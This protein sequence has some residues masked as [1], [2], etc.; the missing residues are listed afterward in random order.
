M[1]YSY[2]TS[3]GPRPHCPG[4]IWKRRFH[5]EKRI[6]CF[7]STLRRRNLK[8]EVSLW[9]RI[10]CF[11]STLR[12]RNLKTQVSLWKRIKCFQHH[13]RNFKRSQNATITDHFGFVFEENSVREITWVSRRHRL[14]LKSSIFKMFP[15]TRK[16]KS[17]RFQ[18]PP[19]WRVISK[20]SVFVTD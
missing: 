1:N 2:G 7:P 9:K 3:L 14:R 4:G 12:R 20:S 11:P 17:R 19:V 18:I 16:T 5:S 6:K 15:C 13:R 8:T 10:K